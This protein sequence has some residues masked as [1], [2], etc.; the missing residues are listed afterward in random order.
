MK[1]HFQQRI[2]E[3]IEI[4][5]LILNSAEIIKS[6]ELA[7]AACIQSLRNDGKILLCGN[8]GSAA[9]AQHLAAELSGRFQLDRPALFAEA[10]NVNSS[11]LTAISNDY[12]FDQV[13]S[14]QVEAMGKK[15]D[16]LIAISTS[17][18]SENILRAVTSAKT[19]GM[20]T[21]CLTGRVTNTLAELCD[22][23]LNVPADSTARIQEVHIMLGHL[24]CEQ[25][26]QTL[27]Q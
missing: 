17:G 20:V 3:N 23:R 8:G 1:D 15:G 24:I 19:I 10:L 6:L 11:S 12:G 7:T 13:F 26:E 18:E 14:R 9:D 16:T 4:H 5:E 27:F 22:I 25:V 21:V 2:R